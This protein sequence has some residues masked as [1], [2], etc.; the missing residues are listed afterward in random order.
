[1][2]AITIAYVGLLG[3]VIGSFLTVVVHRVPSGGSI[4][5]PRSYCPTCHTPI[6]AIDNIPVVSYVLRRGRCRSC[7]ARIHPRY[8][9]LELLTGALFAAVAARVASPWEIPAYCLLAATLVALSAIDLMYMRIPSKIVYPSGLAGAV[10]LVVASAGTHEWSA[11]LR[12]LVGGA[13]AL[14]VILT[15]H[16][17]VPRGMGFGDVR[18]AGLCGGFLGW[19]GYWV[20]VTGIWLSFIVGG[21]VAV[22]LLLGGRA[23]KGSHVP[24][25]PFLAVGTMTAVFLGPELAHLHLP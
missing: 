13:A 22:V 10:L 16:L 20:D 2:N 3:L 12:A 18:L 6:R 1:M 19:L 7:N 24:F 23:S 25:G 21:A 14:G 8:V 17:I 15:I 11:L 4:V 9:I 5:G